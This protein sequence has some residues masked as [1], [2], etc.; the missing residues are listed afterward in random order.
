MRSGAL[1]S[2][3][4]SRITAG[5]DPVYFNVFARSVGYAALT[6]AICA[7]LG[8]PVACHRALVRSAPRPLLLLVIFRL[9]S[10]LIRR[11]RGITILKSEGLLNGL[12]LYTHVITA[13]F[14]L[15]YT[16]AAGGRHSFILI[17]L[18]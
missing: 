12:L 6:T 9:T 7:V 14:E 11:T 3:F 5:F 13:P 16:P 8:Y 2:R 10:F 1:S 4:H 18:S 15:L 17:S